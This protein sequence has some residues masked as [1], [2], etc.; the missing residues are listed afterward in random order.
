MGAPGTTGLRDAPERLMEH[1]RPHRPRRL[2]PRELRVEAISAAALLAVAGGMALLV[3][4]PRAPSPATVALYAGLYVA[5]ARVRL[6]V[7]AGSALPTQLIFVPMLFALPLGV[8]P[9]VVAGGL[10][11]SAAIDVA[12]GRAH[13]ERIVTAIGDG[14]HAVAP[15]GVLAL[16]GS[17]SPEPRHWP[18]F[19][20]AFA[21]QSGVMNR[22][23]LEP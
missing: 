1:A 10:A 11:A 8:V 7:G 5:A 16:A 9:L 20:V 19:A 21:A 3:S 18:L 6:Y 4:S 14:W 22:P 17:P 15:A 13:P 23:M 2:A 12:L